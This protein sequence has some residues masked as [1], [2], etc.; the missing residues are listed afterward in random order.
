MA[1]GSKSSDHKMPGGKKKVSAVTPTGGKR[2]TG[3]SNTNTKA[4][5]K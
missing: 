4:I 5:A 3:L 1:D 2:R